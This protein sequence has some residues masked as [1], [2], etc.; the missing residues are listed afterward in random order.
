MST[1]DTLGLIGRSSPMR[2]VLEQVDRVV[3][4]PRGVLVYGEPGT[5]RGI[6]ARAIHARRNPPGAPFVAVYCAGENHSENEKRLFGGSGPGDSL[7]AVG[8]ACEPIYPG[9]ALHDAIGGT[10][11]FRNLEE[12]PA[13]AQGRLA[14]L[15]RDRECLVGSRGPKISYDVRPM[16]AVDPDA[17]AM[18]KD[19]R[20]RVDLYR[21]FSAN[22]IKLPPLRECRTEIP[23]LAGFLLANA[24]HKIDIPAKTIDPAACSVLAAMPWRGNVRELMGLV[25][26]LTI[27]VLGGTIDLNALLDSV[28]LE[29]SP[30][31]SWN[32]GISLR[33]ARQHFERDYIAAVVAQHQ[34]RVSAAAR[35]LGIQRTNLYRKLR[36]LHIT[37][38]R[39]KQPGRTRTMNG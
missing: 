16:A 5:G 14:R 13:G 35:A 30:L 12:L 39:D 25:E 21:R 10:I 4:N 7:Q 31:I 8:R 9:S 37:P 32:L 1:D 15:L 17:E 11:Y 27:K 26:T 6:V 34:G 2:D 19:G 20:L 28:R 38:G 22:Q 33:D 24:C 3:D 29:G 36:N 23:A 18:V